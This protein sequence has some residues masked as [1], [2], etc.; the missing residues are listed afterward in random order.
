MK[1]IF[2]DELNTNKAPA[3]PRA[4]K[5]SESTRFLL[6]EMQTLDSFIDKVIN[7]YY[8]DL[9]EF[10]RNSMGARSK[11]ALRKHIDLLEELYSRI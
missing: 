8:Y 9:K 1:D 11:A 2:I 5:A 10:S 7:G 3:K 4:D 6:T